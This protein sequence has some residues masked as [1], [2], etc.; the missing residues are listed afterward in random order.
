[1]L[2][3]FIQWVK[4]VNI[5]IADGCLYNDNQTYRVL[6]CLI[7]MFRPTQPIKMKTGMYIVLR[8]QILFGSYYSSFWNRVQSYRFVLGH[9]YDNFFTIP[10]STLTGR[11]YAL[12][13]NGRSHRLRYIN[14]IQY[15]HCYRWVRITFGESL[16]RCSYGHGRWAHGYDHT[17]YGNRYPGD[18]L[19]WF[20]CCND[21]SLSK[22][23]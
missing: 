11:Y 19:V 13:C 1:M 5:P 22:V 12:L 17:L 8:T 4:P 16:A 3:V 23:H 9:K 20:S 21:M 7:F 2:F 15:I 6:L 14:N 10:F 18:V